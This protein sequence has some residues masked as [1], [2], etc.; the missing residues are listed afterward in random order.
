MLKF[1]LNADYVLDSMK[2]YEIK[3]L[4]KFA[5]YKDKEGWEQ[6]RLGAYINACGFSTKKL[7][8]TDIIQFS[9]EA[10]E[11]NDTSISN[12]DIERLK[13]KAQKFIDNDSRGFSS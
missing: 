8:P 7:K 9:W 13:R 1:G 10:E 3:S 12:E 2:M 11:A 6:A 4:F 5:Y